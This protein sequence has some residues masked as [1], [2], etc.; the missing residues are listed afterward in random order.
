M[1]NE[2]S[3]CGQEEFVRF[4]LIASN[5]FIKDIMDDAMSKVTSLTQI[6]VGINPNGEA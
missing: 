4:G 5:H 1:Y 6:H 3:A 2:H